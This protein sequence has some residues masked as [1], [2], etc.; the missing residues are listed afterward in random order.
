MPTELGAEVTPAE[1]AVL[2]IDGPMT[3]RFKYHPGT[4]S[5]IFG[6]S[7]H[8]KHSYTLSQLY[9]LNRYRLTLK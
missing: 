4:I 2:I 1:P 6:S 9:K 7:K 3:K 8:L 5:S